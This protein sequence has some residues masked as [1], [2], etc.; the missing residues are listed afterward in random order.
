VKWTGVTVLGLLALAAAKT[1][2]DLIAKVVTP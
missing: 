1:I 2:F